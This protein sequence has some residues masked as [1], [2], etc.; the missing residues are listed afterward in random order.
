MLRS[1]MAAIWN[2]D[3]V[4]DCM[5]DT[6]E[7]GFWDDM[8]AVCQMCLLMNVMDVMDDKTPSFLL[9]FSATVAFWLFMVCY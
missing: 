9:C 3:T 2:S 5:S 6:T 8:I 7:G 1:E 4:F